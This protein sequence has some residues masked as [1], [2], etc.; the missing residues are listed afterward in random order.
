MA[1]DIERI[2]RDARN[3]HETTR[4]ALQRLAFMHSAGNRSILANQTECEPSICQA[5]VTASMPL[6]TQ[7]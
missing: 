5:I 2:K 3:A 6:H 7:P 1:F 4:Q